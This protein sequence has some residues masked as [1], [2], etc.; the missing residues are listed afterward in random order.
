ML[1]SAAMRLL[2]R[3]RR[4]DVTASDV[5]PETPG[6]RLAPLLTPE[7]VA[8]YVDRATCWSI[9][10]VAAGLQVIAGTIG[11]FT[12]RRLNA[13]N[14]E[15]TDDASFLA[16]MD[17]AVPT[18][19]TI[20]RLVEDLVLS[21]YAYLVV[22]ARFANGRPANARYVPFEQVTELPTGDFQ[23]DIPTVGG[24][25]RVVVPAGDVLVFPSHWP[26]LL[27]VGSRTLTTALTLEAAACRLANT[28]LPAGALKNTGADLPDNVI[29]DLLERWEKSRR[30]RTVGYLNAVLD[31]QSYQWDAEQ[32]QLVGGR[33]HQVAEIARL[34]SLPTRYVNAPTNDSMTYATTEGQ[35]RDL[36]D[37]PLRPY[38]GTVE[39]RLSMDDVTAHGQTVRFRTDDFL[40][41]ATTERIASEAAAIAARIYTVEEA[42]AMEHL[43]ALNPT[44]PTDNV[45]NL[46][47]G[48]P[49]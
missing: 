2:G 3:A 28:D 35:R 25:R 41:G 48:N 17:P 8:G 31:F 37:L 7:A 6:A 22:L 20:T 11:T 29:D 4:P 34:L 23:L 38:I 19:H 27:T 39:A 45:G 13:S 9:P 47:G 32:L 10:A 18:I 24:S 36:I 1:G 44:I 12:L 49:T 30:T 46:E 26:G 40:R 14:V 15:V 16:Q 33:E 43:P 42:R 5:P 21:P